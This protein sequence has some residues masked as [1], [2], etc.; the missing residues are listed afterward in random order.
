MSESKKESEMDVPFIP[1]K[2]VLIAVDYNPS[3][4]K[5]AEIGYWMGKSMD[6]EVVLLHVLANDAYYSTLEPTPIMGFGNFSCAEFFLYVD[7]K[8]LKKAAEYYLEE[9]AIH[10]GDAKVKTVLKEGDFANEVLSTA[11]E[12]E[13]DVIVMG[14][15]SRRWL[16]HILLG[17]VTEKVLKK[18]EIPLFIIPTKEH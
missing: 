3:A 18:T 4:Q 10:L 7:S 1:M 17:S 12:M 14:S 2:R 15:H 16:E 13:A 8:G 6:A 5:V 11:K 9:I